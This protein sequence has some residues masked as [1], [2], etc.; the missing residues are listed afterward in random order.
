MDMMKMVY[1]IGALKIPLDLRGA[2]MAM[3]GFIGA[4]TLTCAI[5]RYM[6]VRQ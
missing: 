1:G 4:V 5:S 6:L 2:K 3:P